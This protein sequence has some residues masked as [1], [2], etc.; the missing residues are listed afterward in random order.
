MPMST[1]N[2]RDFTRTPSASLD[3][4]VAIVTGGA[5]GIGWATVEVLADAGAVPVLLD[6]D[7]AALE[8]AGRVLQARGADYLALHLVVGG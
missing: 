4:R 5:K 7:A 3:G 8:H 1:D 6:R 2:A